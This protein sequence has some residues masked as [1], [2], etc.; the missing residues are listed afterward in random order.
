M[1][2]FESNLRRRRVELQF[3]KV[4]QQ[5]LRYPPWMY[6]V[7]LGLL[8]FISYML[9]RP[10]AMR[11]GVPP[12]FYSDP[13][14]STESYPIFPDASTANLISV[15]ATRQKAVVGAFKHAW[16]AYERD[17]MGSDEYHPDSGE[18]TDFSGDGGIGYFIVDALDT[19]HLMGLR[20]EYERARQWIQDE[21]SFKR[22]GMYSTFETTIRVLGGLL[23]AYFLTSDPL[24]R[25]RAIELGERIL[26]AFNTPSGLPISTINLATIEDMQGGLRG[27]MGMAHG[28]IAEVASLQLEF[29]YLAEIAKNET[30]WRKAE[31]VMAVVNK[32]LP[33]NGLA[34]IQIDI[35]GGSF[36]D[37]EIRL[38][39]RGDSYYEYLLKQYLQTD[40]TEPIYKKM[41]D[42][43]MQ[44]VHDKL[45]Q[46]T[47][48][49]GLTYI[50]PLTPQRLLKGGK[51]WKTG[52][53]QEHLVCF[54]AGSLM[55]GA[56]TSGALS[57]GVSLPPLPEELTPQGRRDWKTGVE[58]LETCMRTH[59]TA[60][61]LSPE[62]VTFG[63]DP[64]GS[65]RDCM[66]R[67]GSPPYDA[68]YML[69]PETVESLFIAF[70]LTGDPRY[71]DYAW[72]IFSA[73]EKHCKLQTGG[74][75]TVLHV[76]Q[77]PVR[78]FDQM[79]TF[80]M[81]ETFKYLYLIFGDSSVLPLHDVVFNTEA[82]P[83]PI[84]KPSIKPGFF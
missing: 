49:K 1:S 12:L 70:R 74:Y 45:V 82:H 46:K 27:G 35:Y 42:T 63:T 3:R 47:P 17:A 55:L 23:S 40:R 28:N 64:E 39:S 34:P 29:K 51:T 11:I 18:G 80:L 57:Q 62:I 41:Y 7:G 69:R 37:S 24:Y 32:A 54:L 50:A 6:V 83:F 53:R 14:D 65:D 5:I 68:R 20:S 67:G 60:T 71:R 16:K 44:G 38:G 66:V 10:Q 58:L 36:I 84:F 59:E 26:P 75:L 33:E 61:G 31:N 43:A 77:T 13:S 30:F 48:T 78:R 52:N 72:N 79:E 73:I 21:L 25:E 2:T 19:M 8:S 9:L 4:T 76:D 81:S 56:T 15:Q 22:N